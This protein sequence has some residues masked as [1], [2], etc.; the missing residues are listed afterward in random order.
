MEDEQSA[1]NGKSG[2]MMTWLF[3]DSTWLRWRLIFGASGNDKR[4]S[5]MIKPKSR[6]LVKLSWDRGDEA[7][8]RTRLRM[9]SCKF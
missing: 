8:W 2:K 1:S 5:L 9:G 6:T 4:R 7:F 3:Y